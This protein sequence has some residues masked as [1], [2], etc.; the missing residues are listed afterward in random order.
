MTIL[1]AN[2]CSMTYGAEL[3][4]WEYRNEPGARE[5]REEHAWP[6]QLGKLLGADVVNDSDGAA[7]NDRIVRTTLDYLISLDPDQ[8]KEHIAV[9]G[10][11]HPSRNEFP[12]IDPR[13]G[14]QTYSFY[15]P[16][17][18]MRG[19]EDQYGS[20][21]KQLH[22]LYHKHSVDIELDIDRTIRHIFGLQSVLEKFGIRYLF[23]NALSWDTEK[24]QGDHWSK[25]TRLLSGTRRFYCLAEPSTNMYQWVIENRYERK[26]GGHPAEQA[27]QEWAR[28][29]YEHLFRIGD[30]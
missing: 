28:L 8:R 2:G 26:K 10:W 30:V 18:N 23:F 25:T 9:I 17:V 29:L 14:R 12:L 22:E 21:A 5:Y 15:Y 3:V 13:T 27:H 7:S 6:G 4:P 19:Y 11:S 1:Y 20:D 24:L 16:N